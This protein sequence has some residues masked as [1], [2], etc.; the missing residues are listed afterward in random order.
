[1]TEE[2]IIKNISFVFEDGFTVGSAGDDVNAATR[3]AGLIVGHSYGLIENVLV[4][5]KGAKIV[6]NNT[7]VV[8]GT[9]SGTLINT[10][11]V[12]D[13]AKE[14]A[15][16]PISGVSVV[17]LI[18]RDLEFTD[19][20]ANE[21]GSFKVT[22]DADIYVYDSSDMSSCSSIGTDLTLTTVPSFIS[23]FDVIISNEAEYRKAVEEINSAD[24]NTAK[25]TLY[26][27]TFSIDSDIDSLVVEIGRAHV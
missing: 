16:T 26:N 4:Y 20:R 11:L 8:V 21:N 5:D 23:G 15:M 12:V 17:K 27:V 1:M 25:R 6:S 19:I 22:S 7:N 2:G 10:V 14:D 24:I 3:Y 18:G 13:N 9:S